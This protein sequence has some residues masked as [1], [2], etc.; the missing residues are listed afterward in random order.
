M[1]EQGLGLGPHT[2][3]TDPEW[4]CGRNL[5]GKGMEVCPLDDCPLHDAWHDGGVELDLYDAKT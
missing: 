2:L 1:R 4:G 5:N 3:G